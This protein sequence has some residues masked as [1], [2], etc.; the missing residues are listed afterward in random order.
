MITLSRRTL[1]ARKQLIA[2]PLSEDERIPPIAAIS[3]DHNEVKGAAD[4][5]FQP[6][7]V[8]HL[9]ITSSVPPALVWVDNVSGV[10]AE[11]D[12]YDGG[13][14]GDTASRVLER[15]LNRRG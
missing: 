1:P 5:R 4:R 9:A 15:L 10:L 7:P 12:P 13:E 6:R 11:A 8:S 2:S 3:S 14:R